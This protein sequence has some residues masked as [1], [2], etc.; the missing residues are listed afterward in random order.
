[1]NN[2]RNFHLW[3]LENQN[4]GVESN[5]KERFAINVQY[6][7]TGD[8]L[9]GP[10][11]FLPWLIGN[12]YTKVLSNELPTLLEGIPLHTCIRY[13]T[14]MAGHPPIPV[15]VLKWARLCIQA[16]DSHFEHWL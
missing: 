15:S 13:T 7:V 9:V 6:C 2:T 10:H 11:I 1:M 8:K 4:G 12:I 5:F 3:N 16:E 14:N